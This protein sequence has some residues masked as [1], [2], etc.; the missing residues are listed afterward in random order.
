[1]E[2]SGVEETVWRVLEDDDMGALL[3]A[4]AGGRVSQ[5]RVRRHEARRMEKEVEE[6]GSWVEV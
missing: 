2:A 6:M 5:D 4:E 3:V 1:M